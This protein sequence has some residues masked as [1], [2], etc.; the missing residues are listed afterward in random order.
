MKKFVF[1][2]LFFLF[3][4]TEAEAISNCSINIYPQPTTGTHRYTVTLT[5]NTSTP[6]YYF[7]NAFFFDGHPSGNPEH[8]STSDFNYWVLVSAFDYDVVGRAGIPFASDSLTYQVDLTFNGSFQG[9]DFAMASKDSPVN[10]ICSKSFGS[11]LIT[12]DEIL[13]SP[14]PIIEPTP[15]LPPITPKNCSLNIYPRPISG[16]NRYTVTLTN[17]TSAPGYTF[18]NNFWVDGQALGK[19]A[20]VNS[21]SDWY[22]YAPNG[23]LTAMPSYNVTGTAGTPLINSSLTYETDL[24][25]N[26]TFDGVDIG[27]TSIASPKTIYGFSANNICNQGSGSYTITFDPPAT[28]PTPSPTATPTPSPTLTPT[29]TLIPAPTST[30]TMKPTNKVIVIPGV[31][32]SWNQ[33]ALVNCKLDGYAGDWVLLQVAAAVYNP[34]LSSLDYAGWDVSVYNYDWRKQIVDHVPGLDSYV[35][36]LIT[37]NE[38]VDIV[39]HSMGGLVGRAYLEEKKTQS[40]VETFVTAGTPHRGTALA[41]PAWAAGELWKENL[42]DWFYVTFMQRRCQQLRGL[43][44]REA[45]R[46]A[47]PGTQNLLPIS[48]YLVNHKTGQSIP[49]ADM[50]IRNNWLP[51]EF[52]SPY[53]GVQ[54]GTLSGKGKATLEKI[55]VKEPNKFFNKIGDW[56]DGRPTK[57]INSKL[58]DGAVLNNSSIIDGADNRLVNK[59]HIGL[60]SSMA[61]VSEILDLLGAPN[62]IPAFADRI[63]PESLLVVVTDLGSPSIVSPDGKETK[64]DLGLAGL[65]NSGKGRYKFKAG[66]GTKWMGVGK[67]RKDGRMSWKDF[68]Y[69]DKKARREEIEFSD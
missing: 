69:F 37:E 28:T 42:L 17:N 5:N 27:L 62:A 22:I 29:P 51:T 36:G 47:F 20:H 14:T 4:A 9:V 12:Y 13:P 38:R 15:P 39:G 64:G 25:L 1:V 26:K 46:Y 43:G 10:D 7:A 44:E 61:G 48:N 65:I 23:A 53:F 32:G 35:N 63:A 34:L 45:I 16:T 19:P 40:Q 68:D 57:K 8:F 49:E 60:V 11:D 55:E 41:Y 3:A 56:E 6:A 66:P 2:T 21:P 30:P 18:D 24:T 33:D 31:E 52:S 67:F 58:G 50:S 59:D 54:I